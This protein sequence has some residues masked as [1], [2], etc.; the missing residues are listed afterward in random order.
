MTFTDVLW[1]LSRLLKPDPCSAG[2][3]E[4]SFATGFQEYLLD[5][6]EC[7][8]SCIVITSS[9]TVTEIADCT[10]LPFIDWNGHSCAAAVAYRQTVQTVMGANKDRVSSGEVHL[11]SVREN[12]LGLLPVLFLGHLTLPTESSYNSDIEYV[13][14]LSQPLYW[15]R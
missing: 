2:S 7:R 5:G 15:L 12:T 3:G 8:P 4:T 1:L 6:T 14:F 10:D 13:I 11:L 9:Q